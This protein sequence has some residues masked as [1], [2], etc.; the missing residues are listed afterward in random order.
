MVNECPFCTEMAPRA[1]LPSQSELALSEAKG[2]KLTCN[3]M[4]TANFKGNW[5]GLFLNKLK[6]IGLIRYN[7]K[8]KGGRI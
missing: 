8:Q 4:V 5:Q 6:K 3:L 1:G 2:G 7:S